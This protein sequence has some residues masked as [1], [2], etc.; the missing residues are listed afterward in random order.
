MRLSLLEP[1]LLRMWLRSDHSQNILKK[2][3]IAKLIQEGI[4][5][6]LIG[7]ISTMWYSPV[8]EN[9]TL[10]YRKKVIS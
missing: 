6:K 9:K 10:F 3:L 5:K 1:L 4:A 8:K 7:L 2:K